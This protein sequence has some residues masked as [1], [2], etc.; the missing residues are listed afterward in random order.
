MQVVVKLG[1]LAFVRRWID[2][3]NALIAA[4]ALALGLG[5]VAAGWCTVNRVPSP[6]ELAVVRQKAA[7]AHLETFGLVQFSFPPSRP[8]PILDQQP[9]NCQKTPWVLTLPPATQCSWIMPSK[10]FDSGLSL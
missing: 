7:R 3:S 9:R 2:W 10:M 6:V 1:L 8:K 4:R 5:G